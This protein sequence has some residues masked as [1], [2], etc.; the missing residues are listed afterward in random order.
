MFRAWH[1]LPSTFS[2]TPHNALGL[3]EGTETAQ[4]MHSPTGVTEIRKVSFGCFS[5]SV[6][7][8]SSLPG[9]GH[10]RRGSSPW[11][12]GLACWAPAA[13]QPLPGAAHSL[14]SA[15]DTLGRLHLSRRGG[16]GLGGKAWGSPPGWAVC[17]VS[18]TFQGCSVFPERCCVGCDKWYFPESVITYRRWGSF[19]SGVLPLFPGVLLLI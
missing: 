4:K 17:W 15:S 13:C 8:S 11:E 2:R 12:A 3:R 18:L 9:P 10:R 14:T 6:G 5:L 19:C 1:A 16:G 7:V